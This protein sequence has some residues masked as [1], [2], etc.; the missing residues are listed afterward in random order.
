MLRDGEGWDMDG[1]VQDLVLLD[2]A[3]MR[4]YAWDTLRSYQPA[5]QEKA[6]TRCNH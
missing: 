6:Y 3:A 1:L 2:N 5:A 4:K